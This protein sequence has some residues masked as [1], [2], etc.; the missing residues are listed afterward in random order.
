MLNRTNHTLSFLTGIVIYFFRAMTG[1]YALSV[2]LFL[3]LRLVGDESSRLIYLFNN[4]AHLLPL[5]ALFLLP[6]VLLLRRWELGVLLFPIVATWI[7]WYAPYFL[8]R[9]PVMP[10]DDAHIISVLTFNLHAQRSGL[11]EFAQI[12]HEADADIVALQEV[13][14]PAADYLAESLADIYPAQAFHRVRRGSS[15]GVAVFSRYP[16]DVTAFVP[17]YRRF[18]SVGIDIN[19]SQIMLHNIHNSNPLAGGGQAGQRDYMNYLQQ[20]TA[21]EDRPLILA[22]D[23]NLTDRSVAYA[24]LTER[25]GDSF[26]QVGRGFGY[27]FMP[28]RF[29]RPAPPIA[30]IDYVFHSEH[31]TP[32]EAQVWP[33][34][35]SSDHRPLRVLLALHDH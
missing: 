13:T 21:D 6:L 23:F 16:L 19:G 10:P 33:E 14:V 28:L 22:G 24:H 25:F 11:D 30:R 7:I 20:Q 4:L 2:L 29:L 34:Y 32:L 1:A 26:A 3:V 5:P 12:I 31:F 17:T 9:Q 18:L 15:F 8:P 27:T 35:A